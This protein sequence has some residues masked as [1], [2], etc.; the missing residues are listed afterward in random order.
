MNKKINYRIQALDKRYG[1]TKLLLLLHDFGDAI[2]TELSQRGM[3]DHTLE[4]CL[5]SLEKW[6]LIERFKIP[7]EHHRKVF[8]RLTE[9][10]KS[11]AECL[12]EIEKHLSDINIDNP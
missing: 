1:S 6:K 7:E 2:Y 9:E 3:S 8:Y 5:E 12:F 10:G 11:I 4:K